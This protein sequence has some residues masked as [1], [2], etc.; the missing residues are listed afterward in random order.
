M[1]IETYS[2]GYKHIE[3]SMSLKAEVFYAEL[4]NEIF[5]DGVNNTNY[6]ASD[7]HGVELAA[8]NDFGVWYSR[9]NYV[10]TA[11]HAQI[12]IQGYQIAAQPEHVVLATL[13]THFNSSLLPLNY[14]DVSLSHK[15]QSDSY[16]QSD[17]YNALGR[18]QAYNVTTLNYQ[19]A[20]HQH[21]TLN[22]SIQ[23]LFD[24]A[25]GQFIDFGGDTLVVY[26][27]NYQRT[28]QGTVNYQF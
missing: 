7:K 15:Y 17:I 27:T 6:R 22:F 20:D 23:N 12:G 1:Q 5:F 19:L 4:K 10:Y 18:Q 25:N 13:G 3:D 28:F 9:A 14:H 26:P 21:W 11:T 2:I 16:A 24:Q 8:F